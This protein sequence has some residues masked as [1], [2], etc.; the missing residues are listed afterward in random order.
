MPTGKVEK[1]QFKSALLKN[2]REV[3]V[4]TPAGYSRAAK[5]YGLIVLFDEKPGKSR[6]GLGDREIRSLAVSLLPRRPSSV[7]RGGYF[8]IA[9]NPSR[10]DAKRISL[11]SSSM[12]ALD[13]CFQFSRSG[14]Q[15]CGQRTHRT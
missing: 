4:Y 7:N 11:S 6:Q 5:P 1:Y 10:V 3:A 14:G 12:T 9:R 15:P 2:E 8:G 13:W